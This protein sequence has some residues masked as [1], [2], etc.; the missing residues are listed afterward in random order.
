[1][2]SLSAGW[3]A[4]S[5]SCHLCSKQPSRKFCFKLHLID[6]ICFIFLHLF[7]NFYYVSGYI[8]GTVVWLCSR[9]FSWAFDSF[10]WHALNPNHLF[11]VLLMLLHFLPS[12]EDYVL[13]CFAE[14]FLTLVFI[15]IFLIIS[16]VFTDF[17]GTHILDL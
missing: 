1:M 7:P 15:D 5:L 9:L 2:V 8:Y 6:S 14:W 12:T 16:L 3:R 4:C 10:Q 11:W 13:L 17:R